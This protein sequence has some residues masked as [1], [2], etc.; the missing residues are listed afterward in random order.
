MA[1]SLF[2]LVS[3]LSERIHKNECKYGHYDKKC[4]TGRIKYKYCNCF[5]EHTNFKVDLIEY[6]CL[7]FNKN[8]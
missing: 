3:N 5:I 1:S 6:Q 2:N 4:E 7:C 8:Y